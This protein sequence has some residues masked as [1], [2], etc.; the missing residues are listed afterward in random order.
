MR[1]SMISD[2]RERLML[3]GEKEDTRAIREL[4]VLDIISGFRTTTADLVSCGVAWISAVC[5][6]GVATGCT[7]IGTGCMIVVFSFPGHVVAR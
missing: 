5:G 4:S 7:E 3:A 2:A 6:S 1:L